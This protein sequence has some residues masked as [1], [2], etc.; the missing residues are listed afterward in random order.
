MIL[1]GVQP[2]VQDKS[3]DGTGMIAASAATAAGRA[4]SEFGAGRKG[5]ARGSPMKM[6]WPGMATLFQ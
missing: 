3:A 2:I 5:A 4:Y 1:S 6:P